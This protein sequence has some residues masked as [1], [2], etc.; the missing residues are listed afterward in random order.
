MKTKYIDLHAHTNYSD[1]FGITPRNL[2]SFSA[3]NGIDILAKTDHDTIRGYSE[4]LDEANKYGIILIPGVEIST[5]KYHLLALNFNPHDKRFI[6]FL[7][8]SEALQTDVSKRRINILKETGIPI[9]FDKVRNFFPDS[10]MGKYNVSITLSKDK[11][12]RDLLQKRHPDLSP[13]QIVDTYVGKGGI[14][15]D[16]K[17]DVGVEVTKAIFETHRAGGIIGIAHP[18]K[19]IET[20]T[21]MEILL[22]QGIDFMEVQPNLKSKYDYELFER[23]AKEKNLPISYG[24]DYHGPTMPR[25]MLKRGENVLT[26]SMA[27]LLNLN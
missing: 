26:E 17:P 13:R 8:Y 20:L 6:E 15:S 9:T 1:G 5:P 7:E 3:L 23:F 21:E 27:K 2:V 16:L 22:Q 18:P 24:S 25:E 11:E 10:R 19:D 14:A 12:C 4:A